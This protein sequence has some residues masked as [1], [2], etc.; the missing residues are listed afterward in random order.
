MAQMRGGQVLS[1]LWGLS[2]LVTG[3][4]PPGYDLG[5]ALKCAQLSSI[6]YCINDMAGWTCPYCTNPCVDQIKLTA[7]LTNKT[8]DTHGFVA[9][10]D[11]AK[12]LYVAFRGTADLRNW[13]TDLDA[14]TKANVT[15]PLCGGS[16]GVAARVLVHSGFYYGFEALRMQMNTAL[17]ALATTGRAD[18]KVVVTGHSLGAALATLAGVA[19]VCD[20]RFNSQPLVVYNF[21]SPRIGNDALYELVEVA[22]SDQLR[23]LRHTHWQDP[24]PHLPLEMMGYHHVAREYFLGEYWAPPQGNH[25]VQECDG[26]GED[27]K[28]ADQFDLPDNIDNHLQY[29]NVTLSSTACTA[30]P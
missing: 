9:V 2:A 4:L 3:G 29:F 8:S 21:G 18:Y 12:T 28:C 26:S 17:R 16:D 11:A 10:D 14:I 6:T 5:E 20:D 25:S 13:I 27:P 23:I 19:L 1:V 7:V 15:L 30:V 24:V 22:L